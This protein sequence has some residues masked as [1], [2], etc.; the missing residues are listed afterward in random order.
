MKRF[1]FFLSAGLI[2]FLASCSSYR[3]NTTRIQSLDFSQY[4]TYG[5]L[6]GIDSLSKGYFSNDIAEEKILSTANQELEARGLT[7]SKQNPDILFRYISIVNNKSRM[8]YATPYYGM[9]WGWGWYRP[10]GFYG[11]GFSYP[12]GKEKFRYA[13]LILEAVDR[14]T[15][16]VV[17]Q[18]RGSGEVNAP[19]KAINKLPKLVSGIM[20]EY[21]V[22]GTK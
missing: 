4:K 19:E 14:K 10:W 3:Y 7:Y 20:K 21:P 11:G 1:I 17:W 13:H 5:W 18:A 22:A 16:K 6:P 2:L 9:G 15:N 12:V 8:V